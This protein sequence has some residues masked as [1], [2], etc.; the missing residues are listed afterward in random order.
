VPGIIPYEVSIRIEKLRW[1]V[2]R[3]VGPDRRRRRLDRD[4]KA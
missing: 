2:K 1:L 3:W 4:W